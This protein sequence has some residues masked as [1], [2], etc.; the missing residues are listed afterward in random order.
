MS[1]RIM[2]RVWESSKATGSELLMLL[3][4]ADHANDEGICWP[5]VDTLC[6]KARVGRRQG[7]RAIHNL[8]ERGE[9]FASVGGRGPGDRNAFRIGGPVPDGFRPPRKRVSPETPLDE[10][11]VSSTTPLSA[12]KG[13]TEDALRVS[14]ETQNGVDTSK[15]PSIEP[16]GSPIVPQGWDKEVAFGVFWNRQVYPR[17][18]GKPHAKRAFEKEVTSLEE[19]EAL[20]T[21]LQFWPK[22]QQW[23]RGEQYIPHPSTFLNRRQ[24]EDPLPNDIADAQQE[25]S[26]DDLIRDGSVR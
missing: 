6:R 26:L 9:L 20:M 19:F 15:E 23:R 25:L 16:S 11:R 3:A 17:L 24:W 13:V 8:I 2:T 5:D 12:S 7:Q 22:C 1:V 4:I 18:V 10:I 14:P 21:A